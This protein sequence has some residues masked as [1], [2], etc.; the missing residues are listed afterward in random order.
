MHCRSSDLASEG[1]QS[2]VIDP[3]TELC[4]Y[5]A[6]MRTMINRKYLSIKVRYPTCGKVSGARRRTWRV[7]Q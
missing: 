1:S 6:I 5:R 3:M 7:A 4:A 2:L